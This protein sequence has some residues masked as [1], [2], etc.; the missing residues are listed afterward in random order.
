MANLKNW[1]KLAEI[2]RN[3][4]KLEEI[5]GN[6]RKLNSN[7]IG[8]LSHKSRRNSAT[9]SGNFFSKLKANLS[10][11]PTAILPLNSRRNSVK[12]QWQLWKIGSNWR[13][14]G[15]IGKNWSKLAEIG[16][17]SGK[18]EKLEEIVGNWRK[19]NSNPIA[20]LSQNSRRNSATSSGNFFSKLKAN[21]SSNRIAILSLNS[22]RNSVKTQ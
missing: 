20:T 17:N 15:E 12:T 19:F 8:T 22:R 18:L 11:N 21:L 13:K 4:W 2:G 14:L 10:S 1:T 3:C 9:S 7:P 16:R 6:W 5:V